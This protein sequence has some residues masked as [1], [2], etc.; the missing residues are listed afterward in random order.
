M[1]L[2]IDSREPKPIFRREKGTLML[3][4]HDLS[5]RKKR[6][7]KTHWGPWAYDAQT[8]ELV[9]DKG[10]YEYRIDLEDCTSGDQVLDWIFQLQGK[11]WMTPS[12]IGYLVEAFADLFRSAQGNL[13]P[14]GEHR[15]FDPLRCLK[16]R[17]TGE[18]ADDR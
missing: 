18:H 7:L 16:E 4:W 2:F 14:F 15:D 6:K 11:N 3:R 17:G 1:T 9:T 10:G 8:L 12:D 13:C 5:K